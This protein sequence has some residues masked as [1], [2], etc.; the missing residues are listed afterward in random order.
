GEGGSFGAVRGALGGEEQRGLGARG[1]VLATGRVRERRAA[2]RLHHGGFARDGE[3]SRLEAG[4]AGS[5][6]FRSQAK[7]DHRS[8]RPPEAHLQEN[9]RLRTL[10]TR[11][12]RLPLGAARPRGGFE[13]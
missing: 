2:A 1:T 7:R 6:P 11:E 10:W 5:P 9:R 13:A 8:P 4:G 12:R 3:G